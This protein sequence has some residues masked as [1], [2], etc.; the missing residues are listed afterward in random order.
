MGTQKNDVIIYIL[1]IVL[2]LWILDL[3][4]RDKNVLIYS[5]IQLS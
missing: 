3:D 1:L 2:K 4:N 5:L